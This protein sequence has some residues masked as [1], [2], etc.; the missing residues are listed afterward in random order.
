MCPIASKQNFT[1]RLKRG[2]VSALWILS[3]LR[4]LQVQFIHLTV[5][6][7]PQRHAVISRQ[8]QVQRLRC[9]WRLS[10]RMPVLIRAFNGQV[11]HARDPEFIRL[12]LT[13][14]TNCRSRILLQEV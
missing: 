6:L 9:K 14:P 5:A 10:Q 1:G 7:D 3:T 4:S 12:S 2:G 8:V 11:I 13:G